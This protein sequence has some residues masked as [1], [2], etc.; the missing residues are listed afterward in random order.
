[1]PPYIRSSQVVAISGSSA[2]FTN[3][4]EPGQIYRFTA[5]TDC[6]VKVTTSGGSAAADTADNHLYIK[7]QTLY[8]ASPD[9][10][11]VTTNSYVKVIQ[12][13]AAGDATLSVVEG[14]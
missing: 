11:G 14:V 1:M 8:L 2:G 10:N 4:M 3:P 12:D 6:W 9:A 5:T 7:G 13:S